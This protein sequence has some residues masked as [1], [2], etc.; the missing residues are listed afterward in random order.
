M[1][2]IASRRRTELD[3]IA[4]AFPASR[5]AV[6][7][8]AAIL[9]AI[10]IPFR[11]F[12]SGDV[13]LGD[14]GDIVNQLG[15]STVGALSAFGLATFVDKR[16]LAALVSPWWLLMFGFVLL[17]LFTTG[18]FDAGL[19]AGLFT[20]IGIL[21]VSAVLTLP[22]DGDGFSTV[23]A[24]A[25]FTVLGL[26]YFGIIVFPDI[27]IHQSGSIEPEHAGFW[28]GA[29]SHKNIAGPVMACFSFAGIYLMRRGQRLLGFLLFLGSMVFML[30]TGSKTTAGLVPIVILVV[31]L[32]GLLGA[33]FLVPVVFMA[34][35]VGAAL[36]TVGI[37][38]IAP[39]KDLAATILP[40]LTYTGRTE[41]WAYSGKKILEAPWIGYGYENFWRTP[42]VTLAEQ[43]FDKLWDIRGIVHGHNGYLDIA[44]TLGLPALAVALV[45]FIFV[46]LKDY[47]RVPHLRE[48]IWL[49]DLF[50]MMA[51]FTLLN[52]F[53]E[54]FFFRRVDP[55]WLF[56]VM[57]AFG[58]RMVARFPVPKS[59]APG[60]AA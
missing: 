53:L 59:R 60:R 54:S 39:L 9:C 13:V 43:H 1:N 44:V 49:A 41:L 10:L 48:N 34:A 24:F 7:L 23:V 16:V 37:V 25:G 3:F 57:S 27:A 6:I 28:R 30:N 58:L 8:A 2:S 29:F 26:S 20:L 5:V 14:G 56:F 36:G 33:R 17:G 4:A 35:I 19:R 22:R 18:Q 32:P 45:T 31:M 47:A 55:V 51:A 46:P 12:S 50:L 11:L 40:D 15:F 52:A 21:A 42:N 38:F